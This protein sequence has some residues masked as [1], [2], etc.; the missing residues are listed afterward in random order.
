MEEIRVPLAAAGLTVEIKPLWGR[1]PFN[2]Y[3]VVARRAT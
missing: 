1:T 2:S 3:L